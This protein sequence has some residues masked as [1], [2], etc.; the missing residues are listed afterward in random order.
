MWY[1][2]NLFYSQLSAR[3]TSI[4]AQIDIRVISEQLA[5]QGIDD[6]GFQNTKDLIDKLISRPHGESQLTKF[7]STLGQFSQ[8]KEAA[9]D[10][11]QEWER[12]EIYD[13]NAL[14]QERKIKEMTDQMQSI[15]RQVC[16][17][18]NTSQQ[19]KIKGTELLTCMV[20]SVIESMQC[21]CTLLVEWLNEEKNDTKVAM[22]HLYEI[23]SELDT[24]KTTLSEQPT[25]EKIEGIIIEPLIEHVQAIAEIKREI[26]LSLN[27]Q[28]ASTMQVIL[29]SLI[30]AVGNLL[31]SQ[32][33]S[34]QIFEELTTHLEEIKQKIEKDAAHGANVGMILGAFA[35]PLGFLAYLYYS[36]TSIEGGSL[37]LGGLLVGAGLRYNISSLITD[38]MKKQGRKEGEDLLHKAKDAQII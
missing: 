2:Y 15:I 17:Q 19:F 6:T 31:K 36:D 30:K 22:Y 35:I 25:K 32:A 38:N 13:S 3:S 26:T 34:H 27:L 28:Q 7:L 37:Y 12:K 5:Q 14:Q 10:L 16:P 23:G 24:L 29:E 11:Q 21:Y 9:K 4:L 8:Y 18:A 33:K 20:R 1:Q